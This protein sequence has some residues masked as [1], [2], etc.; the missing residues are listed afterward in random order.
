MDKQKREIGISNNKYDDFQDLSDILNDL[1][2]SNETGY[3]ILLTA[4]S[5]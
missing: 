2:T 5:N 1:I 3:R 4:N